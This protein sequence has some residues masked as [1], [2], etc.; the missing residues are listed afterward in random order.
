MFKKDKKWLKELLSVKVIVTL[1]ELIALNI[2]K[3]KCNMIMH[4]KF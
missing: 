4:N 3:Y 2:I 1:V